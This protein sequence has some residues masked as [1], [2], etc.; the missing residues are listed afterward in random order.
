MSPDESLAHGRDEIDLSY[1]R[2]SELKTWKE[3]AEKWDVVFNYLY[4]GDADTVVGI[5]KRGLRDAK[6]VGSAKKW[7]KEELIMSPA[8][9]KWYTKRIRKLADILEAKA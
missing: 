4:V 1:A 2:A 5:L 9:P 8:N 3:K 6:K 7:L